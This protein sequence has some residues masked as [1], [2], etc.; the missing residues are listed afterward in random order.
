MVSTGRHQQREWPAPDPKHPDSGILDDSRVRNPAGGVITL[1]AG[2]QAV[3]ISDASRSVFEESPVCPFVSHGRRINAIP[4]V[5]NFLLCLVE[6]EIACTNLDVKI[7]FDLVLIPSTTVRDRRIVGFRPQVPRVFRIAAELERN[8]IVL[9]ILPRV[10]ICVGIFP[11]R[12]LSL[13]ER[14]V[15]G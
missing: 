12:F 3:R 9:F 8:Q 14:N 13:V 7:V 4:V 15:D 11:Y 10:C 1:H 5:H 2:A 6:G